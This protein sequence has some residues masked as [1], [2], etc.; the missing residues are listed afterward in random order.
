MFVGN[1]QFAGF[2]NTIIF[3]LKEIYMYIIY[4]P[5]FPFHFSNHKA[6]AK[7]YITRIQNLKIILKLIMLY[8]LK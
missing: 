2:M 1:L 8:I 4:F 7:H 5:L 6:D 3:N